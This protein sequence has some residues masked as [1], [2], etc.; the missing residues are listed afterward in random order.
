MS[1]MTVELHKDDLPPGRNFGNAVAIDTET[2]GLNPY[3]DRLCLVQM[4]RGD[5]NAE[6]V[7][8]RRHYEAP[9]L[10][11]LLADESVLKIF[12]FARFD[13]AVLKHAFGIMP[14]PVYCTKIASRLA[15][16]FT[17]RHGLKDLCKEMLNIELSK[18]QQSSDWGADQLTPEQL[19]YAAIDV[20]YLHALR[21][22][23]EALLLREARQGLARACFAFLPTRVELDL[24]GWP[25]IDPFA[26]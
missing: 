2:L 16:T 5:G 23:L 1:P 15:R 6:L 13:M 18:Q 9:E 11:R 8:V 14:R 19:N 12:H 26:H 4:S 25:E 24:Q 10:K 21:E 17:D 7:Q 20:L 22:K 3:R